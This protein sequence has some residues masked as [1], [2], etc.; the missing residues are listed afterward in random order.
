MPKHLCTASILLAM[1]TL[2]Q[3]QQA[4]EFK[5]DMMSD[6]LCTLEGAELVFNPDGTGTFSGKVWTRKHSFESDIWHIS[7]DVTDANGTRLFT[8]GEWNSPPMNAGPRSSPRYYYHSWNQAFKFPAD[9]L[10]QISSTVPKNQ[11]SSFVTK[12]PTRGSLAAE[13]PTPQINCPAGSL[14]GCLTSSDQMGQYLDMVKPLLDDFFVFSYGTDLPRP[15]IRFVKA[16]EAG[17]SGCSSNG[18]LPGGFDQN[19]FSYCRADSTIYVG[20]NVMWQIYTKV[21]PIAPVLGLAHEWG[22]HLQEKRHVRISSEVD[23]EPQADCV[24]GAWLS[25][26]EQQGPVHERPRQRDCER[27]VDRDCRPR[28]P[29]PRDG[30]GAPT[31]FQQGHYPGAR[32]LRPV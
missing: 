32:R 15:K 25:V 13:A 4:R 29:Q 7:F 19:S 27:D 23:V 1:T 3:A 14:I 10:N 17:R 30:P 2:A 21:G 24:A 16:A 11:C 28:K 22:H 18:E 26:R 12:P 5:W 9:L 20:E 6:R 8:L 31:G